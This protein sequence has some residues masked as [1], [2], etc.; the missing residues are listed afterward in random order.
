ME[1]YRGVS[2]GCKGE[3]IKKIIIDHLL[4]STDLP[5][6][7]RLYN[8]QDLTDLGQQAPSLHIICLFFWFCSCICTV[9]ATNNWLAYVVVSLFFYCQNF[10]FYYICL[11]DFSLHI[12]ASQV[13]SLL[14]TF[15]LCIC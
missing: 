3:I 15:F 7:L 10:F 1:G 6:S 9:T 12:H 14:A 11:E 4:N 13:F 5:H 2:K 8:L